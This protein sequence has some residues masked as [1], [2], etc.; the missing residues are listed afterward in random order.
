MIFS[1]KHPE[2]G[3]TIFG[4]PRLSSVGAGWLIDWYRPDGGGLS[5]GA[6][7]AKGAELEWIISHLSEVATMQA[8]LKVWQ[9][10]Q[11]P[12]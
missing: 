5:D 3:Q 1:E 12:F 8:A 6:S 9:D 7:I 2:T 4:C 11:I 10:K